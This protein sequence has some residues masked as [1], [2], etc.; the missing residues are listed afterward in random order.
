MLTTNNSG[1]FSWS[2]GLNNSVIYVLGGWGGEDVNLEDCY[3][4]LAADN[5]SPFQTVGA[6]THYLAAGSTLRNA[7][8]SLSSALAADIKKRTTWPPVVL[9]GSGWQ[10]NDLTLFPQAQ[11]NT[12]APDLGYHYDPIDFA[13]TGI[14]CSN[15]IVTVCAGTVITCYA[16]GTPYGLI[17]DRNSALNSTG[18]PTNLNR[19]VRYNTVQEQANTNWIYRV[20]L[21]Q[22]YADTPGS[23]ATFRARFTE[24]TALTRDVSLF[25]G[26]A[27][28][29]SIFAI[30]DSQL[31][32]GWA[33]LERGTL[34]FTNSLLN[35]VYTYS[36]DFGDFED[37]VFHAHNNT[38]AG[39]A[40][41]LSHYNS[42]AWSMTNNFFRNVA[43]YQDGNV[44]GGY[45]AYITNIDCLRLTPAGTGDYT[46][47]NLFSFDTGLLG[48]FYLPTNG[49]ATNLINRGSTYATNVG[50]Y[51]Y[52]TTTNQV[53]E[54]V[55]TNDIGFHYV[56]LGNNGLPIDTDSDGVPDYL[57]DA[58]GNGVLDHR[59][60]KPNDAADRG[61]RVFITRP[62]SGSAIP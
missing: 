33:G 8:S 39:G 41:E 48:T 17:L 31:H 44:P 2:G 47:S 21:I 55:T 18:N 58:N 10:T 38:F 23:T 35:R 24:L 46:T 50:L 15:N 45:N 43:I 29:Y 53:I 1:S 16:E 7:G 12:G 14:R 49:V 36:S 22:S 32:G 59:E 19:F 4:D 27:G 9:V 56:A 40:V 30:T 42:A 51:H 52:T 60:T 20:P 34:T 28:V 37:F 11:R 62:K 57:E 6:A 54:G 13:I 3:T 61:L 25:A 26:F 5:D